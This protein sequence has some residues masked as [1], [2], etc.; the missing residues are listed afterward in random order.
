[1]PKFSNA[2]E[3]IA[4]VLDAIA[5]S[6]ATEQMTCHAIGLDALAACASSATFPL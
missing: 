1:M 6:K 3:K 5:P 2:M 4:F